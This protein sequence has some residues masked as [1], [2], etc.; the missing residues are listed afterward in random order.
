[1]KKIAFLVLF[2]YVLIAP[3][4][5]H[6]DTKLTLYYPSLGGG[7]V[8]D[9]YGYLE[10]NPNN[11]PPFHYPP[12]HFFIL[13]GQYF[14]SRIIGGDGFSEWLAS[15]STEAM[16]WENFFRYNIAS[17][18]PV[19]LLIFASGLILYKMTKQRR[20][21][22]AWWLNPITIYSGVMMGQNDIFAI[23]PFLIGLLFYWTGPIVA[24]VFFG[25]AAAVKTYP[26]I[27][28]LILGLGYPTKDWRKKMGYIA[29]SLLVYAAFL[30]PFL[31]NESFLKEVMYSGLAGR[32][33]VAGIDLGFGD[34]VFIAPMLLVVLGFNI[35]RKGGIK[36]IFDVGVNLFM[37]NL[38]IL[39]FSHFHP[40]WFIWLVPFWAMFTW[41]RK[42]EDWWF[43]D[44]C[45]LAGWGLV[46]L[47]FDDRFLS[48]G[49]LLPLNPGL[50]S[51]PS[52]RD[53]FVKF[54]LD[55]ML[56]NNLAHTVVAGGAIYYLLSF[57][58][59]I[60]ERNFSKDIVKAGGGRKMIFSLP[61]V[62][63]GLII[64][65]G[66]VP[67]VKSTKN[68]SNEVKY[69]NLSKFAGVDFEFVS[70]GNGF[71]RI[72]IPFK[73]PE[74]KKASFRIELFDSA[75][76]LIGSQDYNWVN[77]GDGNN[78]R[79]DFAKQYDS[80][81]KG[82]LIRITEL[83][84][85][86]GFFRVGYNDDKVA[87]VGYA[88]NVTNVGTKILDTKNLLLKIFKESWWW[89]ILVVGIGYLAVV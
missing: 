62:I 61:L 12:L 72:E 2:I 28:A 22:L 55:S 34:T 29:V 45:L 74:N 3:L 59:K 80:A 75:G 83:D 46:T 53:I 30:L 88:K 15:G 13:K 47:L 32:M 19:L 50:L 81:G 8:W 36:N 25:M 87:I 54:G 41:R 73:N 85:D 57:S 6:P 79:L 82:Y 27:W 86:A 63:L 76:L 23:L 35:L 7:R 68:Y 33:F 10:K 69:E 17:K 71:Y 11:Y 1:M 14:L 48:W 52:I 16:K 56:V 44:F 38:I 24:F 5:Y 64:M 9:I 89:W 37:V 49:I 58:K 42:I 65:V 51:L 77:V 26:L 78:V 84:E 67:T 21:A 60:K 40:Q 31:G 18:L 43:V 20:V 66:L 70:G 4:S 39:G